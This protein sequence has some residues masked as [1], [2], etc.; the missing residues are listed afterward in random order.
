MQT[1]QQY[2]SHAL[3]H[4]AMEDPAIMYST[5][6]TWA[7]AVLHDTPLNETEEAAHYN[8][9]MNTKDDHIGI[10][11]NSMLAV[12]GDLHSAL[13]PDALDKLCQTHLTGN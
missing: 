4:Y 6:M 9:F 12:L 2:L 11:L 5:A 1:P 7:S 8:V 13:T 3:E 10:R